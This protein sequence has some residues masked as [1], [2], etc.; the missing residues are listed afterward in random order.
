MHGNSRRLRISSTATSNKK[1]ESGGYEDE[2]RNVEE[3][4][5]KNWFGALEVEE[6][7][8]IDRLQQNKTTE[9]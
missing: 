1:D 8:K 2:N 7:K 4:V 9:K 6:G 3:M 5:E